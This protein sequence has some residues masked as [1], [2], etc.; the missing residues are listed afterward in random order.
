LAVSLFSLNLGAQ[1]AGAFHAQQ[2]GR[3]AGSVTG[4]VVYDT[5]VPGQPSLDHFTVELRSRTGRN[6]FHRAS[7]TWDGVFEFRGV[8]EG[9]YELALLDK[10]GSVVKTDLITVTPY[11]GISGVRVKIPAVN[12]SAAAPVSLR[13]LMHKPPKT[14][15][16]ALEQAVKAQRNG[17][18]AACEG[19]L[20]EAVSADPGYFEAHNN[21]GALLMR[22]GR[23]A[24]AATHFRAALDIDSTA[25]PVLANLSASLL[26]LREFKQAEQAARQALRHDP[27]SPQGH[28]L[29]GIALIEQNRF[30]DEAAVHLEASAETFPKAEKAAAFVR[31]RIRR[32]AGE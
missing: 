20:R 19:K 24:E 6:E 30:T 9:S 8:S 5:D 2:S 10:T 7:V 1:T 17:D 12:S 22:T 18:M 26:A 32:Q 11:S 15:R 14:A 3:H 25:A 23:A 16:K 31:Q 4:E 21:L 28:Y 29:L 13:R 27:N